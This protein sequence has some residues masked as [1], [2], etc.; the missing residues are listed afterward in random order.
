M[1]PR[2]TKL[3][4]AYSLSSIYPK[5][6]K[7]KIDVSNFNNVGQ[8]GNYIVP[9]MFTA[10]LK[11]DRLVRL[12]KGTMLIIDLFRNWETQ[13]KA[14]TLYK[15]GK[16]KDFVAKPGESFHN[17]GRAVD[18]SMNDLNFE[19]IGKENWVSLFWELS[20]SVGFSPIIPFP[21]IEESEVWH[22]NYIGEDWVK[23]FNVLSNTRA[24]KCAVLDVGR[25][26]PASDS[27]EVKRMF[28]QSQLYRLQHFTI[29]KIDGIFGRKTKRA[30]KKEKLSNLFLDV[31]VD[32]ITER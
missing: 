5:N 8:E 4:P 12:N 10:L 1:T 20:M 11:L 6:S 31:V 18:I 24:V 2:R 19:G 27:E 30:L 28:V 21:S 7:N 22:Y 15:S 25:W 3:I 14:R 9:D 17:A 26:N 29:G 16:K 23:I 32:L 13:E